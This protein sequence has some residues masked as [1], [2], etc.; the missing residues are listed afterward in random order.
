MARSMKCDVA[1]QKTA[2]VILNLFGFAD[3]R[4]SNLK[5]AEIL[6]SMTTN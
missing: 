5:D 6:F 1:I 4:L 2:T 3:L